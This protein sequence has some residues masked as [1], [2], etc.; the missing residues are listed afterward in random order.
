MTTNMTEQLNV[1]GDNV[2]FVNLNNKHDDPALS[3][4]NAAR[5]SYQ[6]EKTEFDR[7]DK[8]LTSYLLAHGHG[9]PYRHQ[10]YTFHLCMPLFVMRQITKYQVAST[11]R[12]Y[13][14]D[15]QSISLEAFDV[16]YDTDKGCSWNEVSGRYTQT[17]TEVY[18]PQ[19]MRSNSSHGSKQA[20]SALPESFD[21]A[22]E[23]EHML[24]ECE[25]ALKSY[26][27]RIDRG[28]AK[29][30]ARM[31]LPQNMYSQAYWTV[32]LQ[33]VLHFLAQRLDKD[34][35][36]EI[37]QYARAIKTLIQDDLTRMGIEFDE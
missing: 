16:F 7:R 33:A 22:A 9:S 3:V 28:V 24:A 6:G 23:R 37:R 17:A 35:Q 18:V 8:K 29:E 11:W 12:E 4:V 31:T 32:S 20:S 15:G 34:A 5:I 2:G 14:A 1:L 36:Y 27:A 13:E 10:F 25:Q 21:H 30:I 26:Q 19:V